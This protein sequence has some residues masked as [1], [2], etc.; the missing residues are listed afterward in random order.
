MSIGNYVC[1]IGSLIV[2]LRNPYFFLYRIFH[3]L[4][5]N[6]PRSLASFIYRKNVE[7][8]QKRSNADFLIDTY[9]KGGQT[10]HPDM[11]FWNNEY[12][13]V[14]TPYPYG[15]EEYENP[16]IYHGSSLDNLQVPEAPIAIQPK[17]APGI[18]LSD[19]CFAKKGD[20]LYCYYRESV[21]HGKIEDQKIWEVM[22]QKS[23]KVWSEP[24][25]LLSSS[26]DKVLSPA[27]I[28]DNEGS[29]HVYYVSTLNNAFTLVREQIRTDEN[30]VEALSISGMPEG[31]DLW[32]IGISK[33]ED[34]DE[35]ENNKQ[36]LAGLFLVKTK[37][38]GQGLRLFE[39]HS[40]NW[41]LDWQIIKEIK[42][43]HSIEEEIIFPYKS[44]FIP[45]GKGA[46]VFSFRDKKS[47]NR[48]CI[49]K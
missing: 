41:G 14:T 40:E 17:H 21:R 11:I 35:S 39:A 30:V 12:W 2:T 8:Y 26:K 9:D 36:K 45:N 46:V 25:L 47:R 32:H 16:C 24:R 33:M 5:R 49:L 4:N 7:D 34:I 43:P 13:L 3:Y 6:V 27:I 20:D 42:A 23:N 31:W 38:K 22:Y 10:V 44:C 1:K 28:Y 19:P 18:H 29:L 37:Q 48:L 15:M